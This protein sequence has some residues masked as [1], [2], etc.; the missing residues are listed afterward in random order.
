MNLTDQTTLH[1]LAETV[2]AELISRGLTFATA[3]SCTGGHVAS[4]LTDI[5]GA[6]DAF[7]F[8]LVTYSTEAK[9]EFLGIP[10]YVVRNYGTVSI[11]CAKEMAE[12][13][14][15][16]GV[17]IGLSTTGVIGESI[18]GKLKG[19]VFIG[20]SVNDHGAFTKEL[21][22]DP[23]LSRLELKQEIVRELFEF[24]LETLEKVYL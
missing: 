20:V 16:Y 6:S 15:N 10:P 19:T 14:I 21:S 3:E 8:C 24:L 11:E 4:I 18:E 2:L 9:E 22:L 7:S 13:L 12:N 1:N 23:K 5:D 17:D